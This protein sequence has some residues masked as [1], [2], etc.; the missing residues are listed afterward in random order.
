M[1]I[2]DARTKERQKVL[3]KVLL[4]FYAQKQ[5][6]TTNKKAPQDNFPFCQELRDQVDVCGSVE[7]ED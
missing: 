1:F 5:E 4:E 7:Q 6:E 3:S 2:I